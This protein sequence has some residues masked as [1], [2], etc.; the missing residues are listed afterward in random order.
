[1]FL[2]FNAIEIFIIRFCLPIKGT[3]GIQDPLCVW[4]VTVTEQRM[5]GIKNTAHRVG[6]PCLGTAQGREG[7]AAQGFTR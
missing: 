1:M 3:P 2:L 4:G 5:R 7:R 6:S